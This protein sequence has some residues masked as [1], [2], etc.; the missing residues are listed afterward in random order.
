[1]TCGDNIQWTKV[2]GTGAPRGEGDDGEMCRQID[3]NKKFEEMAAKIF[4]NLMKNI[5]IDL[6]NSMKF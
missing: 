2:R 1:M 4:P 5:L 6:R 3:S